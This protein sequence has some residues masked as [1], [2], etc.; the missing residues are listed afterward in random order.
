MT[1]NNGDAPAS[2]VSVSISDTGDSMTSDSYGY[3]GLTKREHFAAM[4][5]QAILSNPDISNGAT[6]CQKWAARRSVLHADAL[7]EELSK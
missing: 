5:M 4:A 3:S 1:T 2:P 7:L 6:A